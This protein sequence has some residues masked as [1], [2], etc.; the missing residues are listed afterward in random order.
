MNKVLILK[1][2]R[3]GDLFVS[4]PAINL[5]LN[6]HQKDKVE[7]ILS[8]INKA[9]SFLFNI[10]F[11]I[12]NYRLSLF[13]KFKIYNLLKKNNY[14]DVY[15]LSPKNFYYYLPIFFKKIRFHGICIKEKN[16]K[17]PNDY[18][19]SMLTNFVIRDR[20]INKNILPNQELHKQLINHESTNIINLINSKPKIS[21]SIKNFLSKEYLFLQYKETAFKRLGWTILDF[22]NLVCK[23]KNLK[24]NIYLISDYKHKSNNFFLNK[25]NN[26]DFN[27]NTYKKISNDNNITYFNDIEGI[28]MFNIIKN[29]DLSIVPE[30]MA[31]HISVFNKIPT[32]ALC[33]LT[34]FSKNDFYHIIRSSKEWVPRK[35]Y[36]FTLIKKNPEETFKKILRNLPK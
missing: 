32:L 24:K 22:H 13:E 16:K 26:Y 9:F 34:I 7:I 29:A 6:K 17:R 14:S 33:S 25:F 27:T 36:K 2:D 12:F 19:K 35:Y 11:L 4:L 8:P 10:S 23:M 18:L 31:A 30:G 20:T 21:K 15:I 3:I 5:I 28:D 1:N